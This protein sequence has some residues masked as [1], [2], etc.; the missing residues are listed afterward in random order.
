MTDQTFSDKMKVF[1]D[2]LTALQAQCNNAEKNCIVAETTLSTL[3]QRQTQLIEECENLAGC[4]I[5]EV[6]DYLESEGA[7]IQEV[8]DRLKNI[9]ISGELTEETVNAI[10]AIINDMPNV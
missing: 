3:Q 2:Q 5:D 8:M 7:V 1:E 10:Q 4:G 9:D 6:P